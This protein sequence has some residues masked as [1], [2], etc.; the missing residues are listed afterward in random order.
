MTRVML[1]CLALAALAAVPAG[2]SSGTDGP[3]GPSAAER[4]AAI[5]AKARRE[6]GRTPAQRAALKAQSRS[7]PGEPDPGSS[8]TVEQVARL[9]ESGTGSEVTVE[10]TDPAYALL[11]LPLT[12]GSGKPLPQADAL[13]E[14]YGSFSLYVSRDPDRRLVDA[15]A[16][17]DVVPA[18]RPDADGIVWRAEED[19]LG[20]R[21]HVAHVFYADGRVMLAWLGGPRRARAPGLTRI[22]ALLRR[23]DR[24]R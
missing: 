6:P 20:D 12:D 3:S 14:R 5:A 8:V 21:Y 13:A 23:L 10:R 4:D 24:A 7:G 1:A 17:G 18:Q 9:L 11:S 19:A 15:G 22:D 2:C 16:I